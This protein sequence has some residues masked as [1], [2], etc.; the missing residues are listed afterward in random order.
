MSET[1][2]YREPMDPHAAHP[3]CICCCDAVAATRDTQETCIG[4]DTLR[5]VVAALCGVA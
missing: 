4:D 1:I 2:S 3:H 5:A